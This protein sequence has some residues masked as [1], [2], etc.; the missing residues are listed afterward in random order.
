MHRAFRYSLFVNKAQAA[1]LERWRV[2]CCQL[3]NGGLEERRNAWTQLRESRNYVS[4]CA[5]LTELRALDPDWKNMSAWVA[6]SALRR[7]QRAF[8]GFFRRCKRKETPGFPRFRARDRYDSFGIG[9]V[10]PRGDRIRI[11]NL[12]LLRFKQYRPLKGKVLDVQLKKDARG[13]W[14]VCFICDLGHASQ[15]GAVQSIVGIDVGLKTFATLSGD[16]VSLENPRYFKH[17]AAQLAHRQRALQLKKRGSRSR[18]RAKG[19]VARAH[20]HI[21]NQRLDFHRKAAKQLVANYDAIAHE[22]LNIKGLASGMLAKSVHDAGWGQFLRCIAYKA[23]EAGKHVFA[24]DPRGTS[25]RCSRCGENV[26]KDLKVR[27]HDCPHCGYV[28][29][30]DRNAAENILALGRSAAQGLNLL[31]EGSM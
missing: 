27:V 8:D 10:V 12:G 11:P 26:P 1:T 23:E 25:Q 5:A 13:R 14:Y 3:Y 21:K 7:L 19:L 15:K 16:A 17:G 9:R 22:D 31:A 30:R 20:E 28:A 18:R 6:R 4:Q 29:D 2:M 24:V